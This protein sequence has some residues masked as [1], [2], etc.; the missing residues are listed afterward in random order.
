MELLSKDLIFCWQTWVIF[1]NNFYLLDLIDFTIVKI[2][3]LEQRID[4]FL[5]LVVFRRPFYAWLKGRIGQF[6][7]LHTILRFNFDFFRSCLVFEIIIHSHS[8]DSSIYLQLSVF[9]KRFQSILSVEMN[10]M[11]FSYILFRVD[12]ELIIENPFNF[13][14]EITCFD[15]FK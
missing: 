9:D 5:V 3:L 7:A 11:T 8:F 2:E 13:D 6:Y 15:R 12:F 14:I 4:Y 10:I 1:D